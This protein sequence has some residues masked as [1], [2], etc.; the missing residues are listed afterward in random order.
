[1]KFLKNIWKVFIRIISNKKV[2]DSGMRTDSSGN[3]Y[4][5][6]KVFFKREDVKETINKLIEKHELINK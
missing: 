6:N 1:M 4:V 3:I 5:D 2:V